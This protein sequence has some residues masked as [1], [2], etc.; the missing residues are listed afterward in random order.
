[1]NRVEGKVA[2]VTGGGL[3]LGKSICE[4]LA[5]EGAHVV[6]SDVNFE[7]A[8]QTVTSII[9]TGGKAIA[10]ML[11]VTS[12]N[13]WNKVMDK[14]LSH[15]KKLNV[16]VN[17]AG[18]HTEGRLK[19]LPLSSWQRVINVNLDGAF[20]GMRSAVNVMKNNI[21]SSS[22][23]NI[24]SVAGLIGGDTVSYCSSKGGMR[25]LSKS[26]AVDFGKQ[27]FDIR[28][29][30]IF[31]GAINGGMGEGIERPKAWIDGFFKLIP[32]GRMGKSEDIAK[33][34]LFLASD[35]SNF[36]NGGELVI[37]GGMTLGSGTRLLS[38]LDI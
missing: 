28:V 32:L 13:D 15:F 20:L 33:G 7:A 22:I 38:E 11:D 10:V 25:M 12:E 36:I 26:A 27:G 31:P 18:I 21:D 1:M 9:E 29:N 2:L 5:S 23:I 4:V 8:E 24:A 37:D 3:G 16:L 14:T 30:T 34:V 6:V 17:N 19:D 35:D